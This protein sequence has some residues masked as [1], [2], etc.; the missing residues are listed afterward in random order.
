MVFLHDI[1]LIWSCRHRHAGGTSRH[2]KRR[3]AAPEDDAAHR[4]PPGWND[5]RDAGGGGLPSQLGW[6]IGSKPFGSLSAVVAISSAH[7]IPGGDPSLIVG[8]L[9]KGLVESSA[10]IVA[11]IWNDCI[12]GG[13]EDKELGQNHPPEVLNVAHVRDGSGHSTAFRGR[14]DDACRSMAVLLIVLRAGRRWPC[15][16]DTCRRGRVR[17]RGV[18]ASPQRG[19]CSAAPPIRSS[20]LVLGCGLNPEGREQTGAIRIRGSIG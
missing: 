7:S 16:L 2:A 15:V 8:K 19:G 11:Q 13:S 6:W 1:L 3:L 20:S 14:G 9:P 4:L 17:G 5:Y 18:P 12:E 10:S